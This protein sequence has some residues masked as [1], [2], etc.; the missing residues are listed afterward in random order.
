[1]RINDHQDN[2]NTLT[3][4][5]VSWVPKLEH[6]LLS[7]IFLAKK[8]VEM[9][10]RKADQ[11]SKIIIYKEIFSLDDIIENQSIIQLAETPKFTIV[12]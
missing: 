9:F 12:N 5:N 3:V 1:M 2:I 4:T 6:N 11:F 7:T 8:D 10:L